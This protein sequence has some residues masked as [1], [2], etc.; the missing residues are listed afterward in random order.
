MYFP[1]PSLR[2]CKEIVISSPPQKFQAPVAFDTF[3]MR[4]TYKMPRSL[5]YITTDSCCG[6]KSLST[7]LLDLFSFLCSALCL[8]EAVDSAS[9]PPLS[10]VCPSFYARL[11]D[12]N[13]ECTSLKAW[14]YEDYGSQDCYDAVRTLNEKE[15]YTHRSLEWEFLAPGAP[16]KLKPS[17]LTMQTPRRYTSR[18]STETNYNACFSWLAIVFKLC[19]QVP[20]R[21]QW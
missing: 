8:L 7:M 1:T 10:P 18:K 17:R 13:E 14:G 6:E 16:P 15:V 11:G 4:S 5:Q 19:I 2:F 3:Y 21:L 20:V 12:C 9:L